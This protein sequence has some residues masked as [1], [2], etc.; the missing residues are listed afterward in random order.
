MNPQ[1]V[2]LSI[3]PRPSFHVFKSYVQAADL[4]I[5]NTLFLIGCTLLH[6]CVFSQIPPV[7]SMD[8]AN[9]AEIKSNAKLENTAAFQVVDRIIKQADKLLSMQP[10]SVMDKSLTP[11]S[12]NKHDYMSQAPYFWYDSTKPNGLPY[13][14]KDGMRNPE[15]NKITD[16]K[17]IGELDNAT[18]I[19]SLAWYFT[20]DEKYGSKSASLLRH[21]FLDPNYKMNPHLEYAQA[22]PGINTGR[23]IGIIET[24]GLIGIT[25]AA[26]LLT[27]ST[28]WTTTDMNAL[29][30]WFTQYLQWMLTSRNGRD[31]HKA[32]NN[33][34]SW[35]FAQVIDFALFSGDTKTAKQLAEESKIR[36]DSQITADGR[37]PLEL[38]RTNSLGYS[39]MNLAAWFEVAKLA[40]KAGVDLYNLKTSKGSGIR[41]ALEWLIPYAMGHKYWTYLQITPYNKNELYPVLLQAGIQYKDEKYLSAARSIHKD[42]YVLNEVLFR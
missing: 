19:L 36:L 27:G 18:R 8:G 31:E 28:S 20:G 42:A 10:V 14:R 32:K 15:I 22:I 2:K 7:L 5:K 34:G 35:Y 13:Y 16:R 38:E 33:H 11:M 17:N 12:G 39:T 24:R 6:L 21:W 23:G 4:K 26:L 40:K 25:D 29:K 30:E 1:K 3:E 37:Q 9:L 41:P